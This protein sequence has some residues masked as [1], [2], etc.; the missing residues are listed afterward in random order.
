MR[1]IILFLFSSQLHASYMSKSEIES[2][3]DG[4][5]SYTSQSQCQSE[6]SE[7]CY[8]TPDDYHCAYF[9]VKSTKSEAESCLDEA[10]CQ[11]KLASKDCSHPRERAVMVLD[12]DPKEVYCTRTGAISD[13]SLKGPHMA[14]KAAE[15]AAKDAARDEVRVTIKGKIQ[16]GQDPTPEELRKILLHL[17]G[18]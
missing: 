11:A 7:P 16:A 2:C 14:Q 9:R 10:D 18:E 17:L 3:S 12:T 13:Q 5:T 1:L 4:R 8:E 15:K 6:K